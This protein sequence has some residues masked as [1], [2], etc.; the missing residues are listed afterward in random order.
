MWKKITY[1]KLFL[2]A[3]VGNTLVVL[4]ILVLKSFL[5]PVVPL[6]YGRPTGEAQ[7]TTYLGLYIAPGVSF[8]ITAVNMFL[9]LWLEEDYIKRLLAIFSVSVSVLTAITVLKIVFLIGFF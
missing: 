4:F 7:L 5:P 8:L 9:N 3:L 2:A 1:K 6:F